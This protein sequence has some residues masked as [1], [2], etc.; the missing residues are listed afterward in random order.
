MK[1]HSVEVAGTSFT[2]AQGRDIHDT[3]NAVVS[4]IRAGGDL[5]DLVV[6][7]NVEVSVLVTPG[8]AVIFRSEEVETDGRDT[9]DLARPFH[10][11]ASMEAFEALI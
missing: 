11:F 4:A 10:P 1:R 9:G 5:V 2:L 8:V 3:K 6:F 7:G